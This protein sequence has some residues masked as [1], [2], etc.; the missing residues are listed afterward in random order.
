MV[1]F[2]FGNLVPRNGHFSATFEIGAAYQ[3]P[4]R[5]GAEPGRHRMRLYRIELVG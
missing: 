5:R 1:L 3:G 4:P 2:G